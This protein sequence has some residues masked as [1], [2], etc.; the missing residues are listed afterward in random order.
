M[1]KKWSSDCKQ[2][3]EL[4]FFIMLLLLDLFVV[5]FACNFLTF[6]FF[7]LVKVFIDV[8][9]LVCFLFIDLFVI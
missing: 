4:F 9:C 6:G 2:Q 5:R 7:L 3:N 8:C 1:H